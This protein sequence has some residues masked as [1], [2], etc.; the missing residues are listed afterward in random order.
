MLSSKHKK[1]MEKM[2]NKEKIKIPVS[3]SLFR[4]SKNRSSDD[5]ND[6]SRNGFTFPR[7]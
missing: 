5:A 4:S 2:A 3:L 7:W 1:K 6:E